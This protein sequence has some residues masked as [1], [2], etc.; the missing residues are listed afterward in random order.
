M[1]GNVSNNRLEDTFKEHLE[2]IT[3]CLQKDW[4]QA[5]RQLLYHLEQ[6]KKAAFQLVFDSAGSHDISI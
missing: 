2:I 4:E 3:F 6:S 5:A 1:T